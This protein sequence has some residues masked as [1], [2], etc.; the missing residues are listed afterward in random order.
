MSVLRYFARNSLIRLAVFGVGILAT[1]L[2]TPHMLRCLGTDTYGTW[3]LISTLLSYYLLLDFGMLQAVSRKSSAAAAQ[4]DEETIRR[5]FST[6]L[7]LSLA[8]FLLIL[9]A[10]AALAFFADRFTSSPTTGGTAL[11]N[12]TVGVSV[13]I[14]SATAAVQILLR[15]ANG[16][17][18]GAMRWTYLA[19]VTMLRTL[20]SSGAILF[21]LSETLTP[22]EN[23]LRTAVIISSLNAVEPLVLF[24]VARTGLPAGPRPALASLTEARDLLGFGLPI[25]INQLGEL[26]RNRTQIYIVASILGPAQ[27]A[28]F[29]IAR[30]LI[31]YM[32]DVMLNVF[33]I[34]SPYFSHMQAKGDSAGYRHSLLESL[35]LSYAVS[36][37][38]G[39]CLVLYGGD[40]LS[41]W[42][43]P[44][45]LAAHAVLSPLALAGII[46]FGEYPASGFLIGLGRH[47][48]LAAF[49]IMQGL[50]IT[51]ISIPAAWRYGLPG[52]AWTACAV[53]VFFS[54]FL[55]PARVC[56]VA[57]MPLGRYYATMA[58]A[59]LPQTI[60]Q[61]GYFLAI[62]EFL[63]ADYLS[64]FL[65][66]TGQACVAG[67]TFYA[68]AVVAARHRRATDAAFCNKRGEETT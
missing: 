25:L 64:L 12:A 31:N 23:L 16:L 54:L 67:L 15:P 19:C 45:F 7:C 39:L 57:G 32:G 37:F 6:A 29:S 50:L 53:T 26:L 2:V 1:F 66:C 27:V 22:S 47:H 65:A 68:S 55:V 11:D 8:G 10:G 51:L 4:S 43:G 18:M 14:F 48:I 58:G 21:L 17:L 49:S 38:I 20:C 44:Q 35:R 24:A 34:L 40:F 33:G 42:L 63:Q 62:H 60:A 61:C 56:R 13:F 5:V 3:A 28:L 46:G 30:Q 41:R 36:C 9:I 59:I 52:V